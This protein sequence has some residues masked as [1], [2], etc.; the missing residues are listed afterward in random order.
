MAQNDMDVNTAL[1][2]AEEKANRYIQ[3]MKQQGK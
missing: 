3:E 2:I 1:R